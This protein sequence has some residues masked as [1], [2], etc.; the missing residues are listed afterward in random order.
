MIILFCSCVSSLC[1][2]D[3]F[4]LVSSTI[5][6]RSP[7]CLMTPRSHSAARLRWRW[8]GATGSLS[9]ST[10]EYQTRPPSGGKSEVRL[11]SYSTLGH[12][13]KSYF[14]EL[15]VLHVV[16]LMFMPLS[17]TL[18]KVH[19]SNSVGLDSS[20]PWWLF[21]MLSCQLGQCQLGQCG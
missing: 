20:F 17:S 2:H 12:A 6:W 5:C 18:F 4:N 9:T 16:C 13:H 21:S 10:A 3:C 14:W 1:C 15:V 11:R 8:D 19:F 7:P